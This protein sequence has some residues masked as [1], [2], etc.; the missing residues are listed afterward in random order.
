[1]GADFVQLKENKQA[2]QAKPSVAPASL[3]LD[4]AEAWLQASEQER[5][6]STAAMLGKIFQNQADEINQKN[7]LLLANCIFVSARETDL[8]SLQVYELATACSMALGWR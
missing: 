6:L 1:V 3:H 8:K 4:S 5:L 7:L 2:N